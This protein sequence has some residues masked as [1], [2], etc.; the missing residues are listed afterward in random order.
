MRASENKRRTSWYLTLVLPFFLG[1]CGTSDM[2]DLR[3]YVD[4]V[5]SRR[6]GR[7]APLPDP[8]A[9]ERF[10]YRPEGLRNP[11][12]ATESVAATEK[13]PGRVN[14][15]KPAPHPAEE[16]ERFTLDSL[17]LVGTLEQ[18]NTIWALIRA[19]DKSIHRVSKGN[20][21]GRNNGKITRISEDRVE[22]TEIVSDNRGDYYERQASIALI[23]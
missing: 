9:V 10:I 1:A 18:N 2:T 3:T 21:M 4:E 5:K 11:F 22:L 15:P 19:G 8:D 23:E 6:A 20:Y 12:V 13:L 7:I 14:G 17:K 16:L